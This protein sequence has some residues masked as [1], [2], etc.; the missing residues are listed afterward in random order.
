MSL[1]AESDAAHIQ[2]TLEPWA[3]TRGQCSLDAGY[4]IHAKGRAEHIILKSILG[5]HL[6]SN[7]HAS[8]ECWGSMFLKFCHLLNT[9]GLVNDGDPSGLPSQSSPLT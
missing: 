7:F 8:L 6:G 4:A 3:R 2:D 5:S 9:C 1:L